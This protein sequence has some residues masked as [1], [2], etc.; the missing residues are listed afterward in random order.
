MLQIL[1]NGR[2][3]RPTGHN[4]QHASFASCIVIDN[5]KIHHVGSQDDAPVQQAIADG[6]RTHDMNGRVVL[7]GLIDS[8]MHLLMVGESLNRLDLSAC[9]SLA[10][11]RTCIRDYA[12]THPELP[13]ILCST[14][15]QDS[16]GGEGLAS[17]LDDID[18]RPIYINAFD[19][20][21]VWCNTAALHELGVVDMPD[22]PGGTIHRDDSGKATG[23]LSEAAALGIVIPFISRLPTHE[24]KL[25]FIQNAFDVYMSSGYTGLVDMAM[26]DDVWSLLQDYRARNG[27]L[28]IWMAVHWLILPQAT[29]EETMRQV[30]RAIDLQRLNAPD[31][32]V[33]GIK[34]MA[35][36]VVDACT[37]AMREP[38][39]HTKAQ[40]DPLW[41]P[42]QLAPVF[43]RADDA[44]LQI[45]IHAIGDRAIAM[46]IDALETL[47]KP[48]SRHRIEHLETCSPE[49]V[50]RLGKLGITASV[51]PVHSDPSILE[52]WS[53]LIGK[54]CGHIFPYA[55]FAEHGATVAIGT[56]AP[57][58]SHLPLPNLYTAT[59]R[60]SGRQPEFEGQTTPQFA[61]SLAAAMAAATQGAAYSCFADDSVG[62]L[63]EGFDANLTVIDME[64]EATKLL[65]AKVVETWYQGVVIN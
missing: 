8:H 55:G 65:Q 33:A 35:D 36:G 38:Y 24:Q 34:V 26:D 31:C 12:K 58:A 6:A 20:H 45:A 13:R 59:T 2:F 28:P 14:W 44:G 23:L 60:R 52:A 22:P 18:S 4:A 15:F 11:I 40:A 19:M 21:S 49:D 9:K 41:T 25:Q 61:L 56:D 47:G 43:K 48:K 37:A 27:K 29:P 46:A 57:T 54:R 42:E 51:Q 7:P 62:K 53:K 30:D 17:D 16:T 64:W 5:G 39:S 63:E 32:R 10:Q 3:F 1:T 50:K